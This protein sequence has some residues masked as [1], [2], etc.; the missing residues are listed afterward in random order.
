MLTRTNDKSPKR[1][2]ASSA[3]A[4]ARNHPERAAILEAKRINGCRLRARARTL[5]NFTRIGLEW[6]GYTGLDTPVRYS[7]HGTGSESK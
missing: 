4:P 7:L 2:I 6:F 1:R 3:V 5:A